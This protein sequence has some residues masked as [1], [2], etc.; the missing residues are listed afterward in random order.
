MNIDWA[1]T[2]GGFYAFAYYLSALLIICYSPLKM[3]RKEALAVHTGFGLLLLLLMSVTHGV[4]EIL[5]VPLMLLFLGIL[6][7]SI[8][9][10]CSYNLRTSFYFALRAFITG[11]FIASLQW[12]IFYY[13]VQLKLLPKNWIA[14]ISLMLLVDGILIYLLHFLEKR[15]QSI[16]ESLEI[17]DREVRAASIIAIAVFVVSNI[18]YVFNNVM[19]SDLILPQLF[20]IRTLIDLG[21]VAILLAFHA[22]LGELNLRF[23]MERLQDMYQMQ[24]NNYAVLEQSIN[25]INQKYHDLKY[26][27][28][29]LK[30]E[31]GAADSMQYLNRMEQEIKAYEAQNKTGNRTLDTI[32]T[33]KSLYC[34]QNWIELTSV[35]DGEALSFMDPMD[36]STL[37]GNM[38]D[39]AIESVSKIEQKER[40][41]IHVAVAKQKGFLRIRV[42]NCYEEEPQFKDGN[43]TTSKSD[44]RYHG[45]GVKSIKTTVKK[46]GGSTT[47]HA[48][49]GWFEIRILIP[50][51]KT[52]QN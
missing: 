4:G 50:L 21:G 12:Q 18:S 36:L 24:Q 10:T 22:Q 49:N 1:S 27:I 42:E 34:Q 20:L 52:Q 26:Q 46:Y 5:F 45:F 8:H 28:A 39:N 3:E 16:N 51:S 35:A 32:L 9:I 37:F 33:A 13:G 41:L 23:E 31:A 11:E 25:T 19:L 29:I 30:S 48:E 47:I 15:N 40:R 7:I 14:A 38:L 43:L 2:P 44:K 6:W 17:R